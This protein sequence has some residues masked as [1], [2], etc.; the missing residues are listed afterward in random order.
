M[1]TGRRFSKAFCGSVFLHLLI[2]WPQNPSKVIISPS[3]CSLFPET[4]N[5]L[6]L[7]VPNIQVISEDSYK[8]SGQSPE[9][10]TVVLLG[11]QYSLSKYGRTINWINCSCD[12][13]CTWVW[14]NYF[15]R[16]VAPRWNSCCD[17]IFFKCKNKN[18][19]AEIHHQHAKE[20]DD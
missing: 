18:S 11:A 8:A 20:F 9:Y 14:N 4:T 16:H 12:C 7:Q 5:S 2:S 1:N 15:L 19:L 13:L 6:K 3:P 10:N 17:L